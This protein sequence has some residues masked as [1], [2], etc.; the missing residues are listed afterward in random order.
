MRKMIK[1]LSLLALL[2]SVGVV[3]AVST[4][5]NLLESFDWEEDEEDEYIY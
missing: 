3:Y 1:I 4:F 2:S 5:G